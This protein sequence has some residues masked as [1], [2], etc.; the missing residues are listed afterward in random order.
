M[1]R[2]EKMRWSGIGNSYDLGQWRDPLAEVFFCSYLDIFI[3]SG[4]NNK[5]KDSN[6]SFVT[7]GMR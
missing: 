1:V 3:E 2:Q 6:F 5:Y 7:N 4:Y